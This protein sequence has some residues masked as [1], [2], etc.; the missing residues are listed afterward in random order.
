MN[1]L[2]F[3]NVFGLL[4]SAVLVIPNIIYARSHNYSLDCVDNKAMLYIER[5]GKYC[6]LFLMIIN[7]GIL[8]QGFQSELMQ[9]FWF[10]ATS[11]LCVMYILFWI[12]FLQNE[13]YCKINILTIISGIIFIL[14]GLL[15]LKTLLLTFGIVYLIGQLYVNNK[16]YK[17]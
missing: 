6:S 17:G 9:K 12:S 8:E 16:F 13:T 15:Q 10:I 3:I 7:I 1:F 4:F 14:S 5:I 11:V 2:N